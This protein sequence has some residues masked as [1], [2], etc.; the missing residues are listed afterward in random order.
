MI[1][2]ELIPFFLPR[3]QLLFKGLEPSIVSQRAFLF[4]RYSNLPKILHRAQNQQWQLR[5]IVEHNTLVHNCGSNK[6]SLGGALTHHFCIKPKKQHKNRA[7]VWKLSLFIKVCPCSAV[8]PTPPTKFSMKTQHF[9]MFSPSWLTWNVSFKGS[10]T[11]TRS[12]WSSEL[13][14]RRLPNAEH[15]VQ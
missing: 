3:F 6:N 11:T 8:F 10:K 5:I 2:V 9:L 14:A 13:P 7:R 15:A 1:A 12:S 4:E